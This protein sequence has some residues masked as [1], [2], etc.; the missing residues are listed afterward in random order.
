MK[1][2]SGF[3]FILT[4]LFFS[5]ASA[6]DVSGDVWGEWNSE[7]NPYNVVGDLHVP[8]DSTLIINPG[9]EI[10]FQ[11]RYS[12]LVDTSATFRAIGTATDSILF[13]ASDIA[14]GWGGA[15]FLD[16]SLLSMKYCISEYMVSAWPGWLNSFDIQ[17]LTAIIDS[18]LFRNN[19]HRFSLISGFRSQQLSIRNSRFINNRSSNGQIIR[20]GGRGPYYIE[21]CV[22]E[23]NDMIYIY[24]V[25]G[26]GVTIRKNTIRNNSCMILSVYLTQM[27]IF[28]QNLIINNTCNETD[29]YAGSIFYVEDGGIRATS[30][31]IVNNVS[32]QIPIG[33]LGSEHGLGSVTL[34]NNIIWGNTVTGPNSFYIVQIPTTIDY[35]DIQGWVS[36]SHGIDS[37]PMFVDSISG[38]YHLLPGSPCIDTGDSTL[39]NDPDGSRSDM[40]A[41]PYDHMVDIQDMIFQFHSIMP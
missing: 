17:S 30:N 6:T 33:S 27:M 15:M 4:I 2:F 32:S 13:T 36:G 14:I 23:N 12:L 11:G 38:D 18:C 25:W 1:Y 7:N 16:S 39:P 28:D 31:T 29:R 8:R 20:L 24:F 21:N 22:I 34:K 19:N 40:G 41:F 26:E 10:I 37:D 9:C 3:I 5:R 35:N